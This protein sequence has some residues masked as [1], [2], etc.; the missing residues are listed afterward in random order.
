MRGIRFVEVSLAALVLVTWL[1]AFGC[2]FGESVQAVC[3]GKTGNAT[4]SIV[5]VE[6]MAMGPGRELRS[7]LEKIIG[8]PVRVADR[9]DGVSFKILVGGKATLET[10]RL[11]GVE[12]EEH[13][14]GELSA[15]GYILEASEHGILLAGKTELALFYA[16]AGFLEQVGVRWFM[17]GEIGEVLPRTASLVVGHVS[18]MSEP[19]FQWRW[20]GGGI[21]ARRNGMNVEVDCGGELRTKWFGHTYSRLVTPSKYYTR[22]PEYFALVK[23][24][25]DFSE[26]AQLCTS[27]PAVAA[28]VAQEIAAIRE[29]EPAL[30]M[31]SLD[32][33][34]TR[35][36][37]ECPRCVG[38]DEAG[39]FAHNRFTRRLILFHSAVSG[40]LRLTY[41]E[42]LIKSHAY[43]SYAAP[44]LDRS[45]RLDD[46]SVIQL[47]RFMCHNHALT[48]PHCPYNVAYNKYLQGWNA[49]SR[50][51]ALYEYYYKVSWL[52]LPWPVLHTVRQDIAYL[53]KRGVFGIASQYAENHGSNGLVYYVLARLLWDPDQDVD[54]LLEDFYTKFY[55]EAA[56]PMRD[57]YQALEEGAIASDVHLARQRPYREVVRLFT[58]ELLS[59]LDGCVLR[60]ENKA[61]DEKVQKRVALVR[62]SL[63]YA[64]VCAEYLRALERVQKEGGLPW[65]SAQVV[66]NA[67]KVGRHYLSRIR[68]ALVNGKEIGATRG[69]DSPYIRRLLDPV[70]VIRSWNRPEYGFGQRLEPIQKMAWLE[71]RGVRKSKLQMPSEI[72][73]WVVGYDFDSDRSYSEC[74][75]WTIDYY[76]RKVTIG[77]LAPT[78]DAGN[79][80]DRC[81]VFQG[82]D[83][84]R[85]I[86]GREDL[87]LF[88]TNPS[89]RWTDA[90]LYAVYVMPGDT[91]VSSAE[92]MRRIVDSIDSVRERALGFVE[93]KGSGLTIRD[94]DT[95][96]I[97]IPLVI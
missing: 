53:S 48:D 44:P 72:S 90:A 73:F 38:L 31:V 7:Y 21:W 16:V 28:A 26:H 87:S 19:A 88:V 60:A 9:V 63:E 91:R 15:E 47:C 32:P 10:A 3:L 68:D 35:A 14:W 22:H 39:K 42:L 56:G 66:S 33:M 93:F 24:R 52:E 6:E 51:V 75:A 54:A 37:C 12:I 96:A 25:R 30:K 1:S 70:D 17:P 82:V 40:L 43:Q 65:P 74:R 8:R 50:K 5:A 76:G 95:V 61:R 84:S 81:Y 58:P 45:T 94:G 78:S 49:I 85:L 80:K 86:K 92:A 23:G 41:P 89:G 2:L 57:Y 77:G 62:A 27:N 4:C 59:T 11:L 67:K 55:A 20:L 79:K 34:D 69:P 13:L 36:F 83:A 71:S 29:A 97:E 46:N 18:A 64:K